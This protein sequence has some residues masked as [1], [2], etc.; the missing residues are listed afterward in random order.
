[1]QTAAIY[2]RI[3]QDTEGESLGV[4]RQE[5]DC[6][7]LAARDGLTVV[8]VFTD[9]DLGASTR[10]RSK[11]RPGFT[12]MMTRAESGEFGVIVAYSNSRL[13]RRPLELEDL[14]RLHERTGV[15]LRTV[16]SGDDDLSTADGRMVAR[17]KASVDAGEVERTAERVARRH[18]ANARAG[19]PVGGTRPFGWR[20]DK[21]TIDE[22]EAALIREAIAD[23]LNG[24]SMHSI[25]RRWNE[26]GVTTTTGRPWQQNTLRQMLK[27]PRL[28]GWRIH[29]GEVAT[30]ASGNPVRG[31]WAPIVDD[32][33]HER[34][35]AFLSRPEGRSRIPRRAARHYLL[36]GVLKCGR[37]GRPM[38]GNARADGKGAGTF[39]YRCSGHGHTLSA[40]SV[41]DDAIST[42]VLQRLAHEPV[43]AVEASWEGEGRLAEITDKIA[44]LMAAYTAGSLSAGVAFGAIEK[45]EAEQKALATERREWTLAHT[46][47]IE[48][49]TP[50]AWERMDTDR[51]RLIIESVLS[52]VYV[53]PA[54]GHSPVFDLSRVQPVWK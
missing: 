15:R 31:V 24:V 11:S 45:L 52:A 32:A 54:K 46:T 53:E 42:L 19:K 43:E 13:T 1:M 39:Y 16:V 4:A 27:S 30:D 7:A 10:S 26:A 41:V 28:A 23:I 37:C 2:C 47:P 22:A 5:E 35:L 34:L 50:D 49:V 6:R 14:I 36:T 40:S 44:E 9:N 8:D 17:I 33:T 51:R 38:Y 18:L 12:S 48:R 20:A 21:V 25:A 3:S 29:R